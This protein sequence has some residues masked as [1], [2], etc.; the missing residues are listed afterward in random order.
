MKKK[1]LIFSILALC[2]F[3]NCENDD[4]VITY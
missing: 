2:L 3:T 4:N 1:T